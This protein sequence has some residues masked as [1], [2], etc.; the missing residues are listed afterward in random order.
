MCSDSLSHISY[1]LVTEYIPYSYYEWYIRN[2][3]FRDS[4]VFDNL[5]GSLYDECEKYGVLI[6][7]YEREEQFGYRE[8]GEIVFLDY[9]E[10]SFASKLNYPL[11]GETNYKHINQELQQK[12]DLDLPWSRF[13]IKSFK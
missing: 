11:I 1:C 7:D 10:C 4:V 13:N 8:N 12:Y 2:N 9:N 5:C 6:E 3:L